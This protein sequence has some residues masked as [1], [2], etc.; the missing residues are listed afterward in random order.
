MMKRSAFAAPNAAVAM[1]AFVM[2]G[3]IQAFTDDAPLN[4]CIFVIVKRGDLVH[5]P[6]E[7]AMVDD[8]IPIADAGYGIAFILFFIPG[9]NAEVSNGDIVGGDNQ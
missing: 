5:S 4:G 6:T 3:M 1:I 8:D 2:K 9:S 7:G